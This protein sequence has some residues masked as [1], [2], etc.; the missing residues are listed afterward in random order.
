MYEWKFFAKQNRQNDAN[1]WPNV[2]D[3]NVACEKAFWNNSYI[4]VSFHHVS[5]FLFLGFYF[6][7]LPLIILGLISIGAAACSMLLPDT[8]NS[9]L[10]DSISQTRPIRRYCVYLWVYKCIFFYNSK[11]RV[12]FF[13]PWYNFPTKLLLEKRIG[14]WG[15]DGIM[16][17]PVHPAPRSEGNK[18]LNLWKMRLT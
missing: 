16:D 13:F 9:K 12:L 2:P 17:E 8:R 14:E 18:N 15:S 5:P 7:A 4:N 10:P 11:I 1:A 3:K 6:K